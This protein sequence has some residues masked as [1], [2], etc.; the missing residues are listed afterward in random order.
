MSFLSHLLKSVSERG[1]A[2]SDLGGLS[3]KAGAVAQIIELSE[4]L[5]SGAGE[6]SGLAT[7]SE[8]L[9]RYRNLDKEEKAA[10]FGS[11]LIEFGPRLDRLLPAA[12]AFVK[13]RDAH[14]A[15][16]LHD[17]S[18]PQRQDLFRKLNQA[19]GGT[20]ALVN[21]RADLLQAKR[22]NPEL[23]AVDSDFRHLFRS[24]FNRGFL[25]LRRIDWHTSAAVLENIIRYEAVHEI[26][27]WDDLRGRIDPPDRRLYAF[28]HPALEDEPLIFVEVALTRDTPSRIDT[29]IN[30]ER[31]VLDPH[32]AKAAIFY[33]ISDCQPGLKGVSFGGFLIKQVIEELRAGLPH[34]EQFA[35]LSPVRG[36]SAWIGGLEAEA[37]GSD[38]LAQALQT[39]R[40]LGDEA[41]WEDSLRADEISKQVL[42]LAA[43]YYVTARDDR[44]SAL[45]PVTRFHLRNGARL[46]RINWMADLSESGLRSSFGVMVN[47]VYKLDQIE[48]NHERFVTQGTINVSSRVK[49]LASSEFRP[50]NQSKSSST[51]GEQE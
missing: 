29:V 1:R 16:M 51:P 12:E 18:E 4:R 14:T 32:S 37:E 10:F 31:E 28:F 7:A 27:D 20:V 9:H 34:V 41:W 35:T 46:D 15:G 47:Y 33:S 42:P 48:R 5:L 3:Q 25:E 50:M 8:I 43:H 44:G 21:M 11:I 22:A 23:E 36:L 45:D 2:L 38:R 6:A 13:A 19:P 40:G 39:L 30:L 26:A 17:L 24:W 49:R